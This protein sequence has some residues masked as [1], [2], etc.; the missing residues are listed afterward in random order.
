MAFSIALDREAEIH[1]P[2]GSSLEEFKPLPVS[3]NEHLG[4]CASLPSYK[5]LEAVKE[6]WSKTLSR[7]SDTTRP[8]SFRNIY[9]TEFITVLKASLDPGNSPLTPP[10]TPCTTLS[11]KLVDE[12]IFTHVVAVAEDRAS[13]T[14]QFPEQVVHQINQ[15]KIRLEVAHWSCQWH[16]NLWYKCGSIKLAQAEELAELFQQDLETVLQGLGS[17]LPPSPP[18]ELSTI[19]A[20]KND[21]QNWPRVDQCIH[22]LIEER[23]VTQPQTE[24]VC[25]HDG[26]FT[27]SELSSTS[28][29]LARMLG[30]F[31]ASPEQRVAI[32]MNKS[33]W[34]PM[35]VLAVLKAGAAFVPLD[36]THPENRLKQLANDIEPCVLITTSQ[37]ANKAKVLGC[38]NVLPIDQVDFDEIPPAPTATPVKPDNAAYIIFTSGS[39]GKPKGVVIEHSA[40]ATSAVTRGAVLGLGPES[41]VLQ[42]APHTFDVSVDEI[43]TTLIHGG[44]VCIPSECDRF[45]ITEF[46]E[47]ARVS[48]ALLTPTSARTINPDDVPTLKTLQTGGEVLTEDVNDKWCDRV[49]LFNVYGPTEAS[50]ACVISNRT[51]VRGT[52]HI[53]GRAVGGTCWVVNPEDVS[54]RV[55]PDEIGELVIAGPILARGYFRDVEKTETSFVRL[56]STGERVYRTG[57]LASM[58]EAGVISYHGRKDLEIKIRGQRINIAEVEQAILQCEVVDNVVVEYPVSGPCAKRL[59]AI[60][61]T[62]QGPD[63]E[64]QLTVD[65]FSRAQRLDEDTLISFQTQVSGVLPTAMLPSKWLSISHLPQTAS[66]KVDRKQVRGWLEEMDEETYAHFFH[67]NVSAT[68]DEPADGLIAIWGK[69]LKI[70]PHNL[71]LN[72]SFIRNGGDSIMAMEAR[73]WAQEAGFAIHIPDLLGNASLQDISRIATPITA[74]STPVIGEDTD[75]PFALSPVQQMYFDHMRD[76]HMGLQQRVSVEITRMVQPEAIRAA[77][78]YVVEKHRMLAAKFNCQN[79]RWMQFV[80]IGSNIDADPAYEFYTDCPTSLDDYCTKPMSIGEGQLFHAHR[81]LPDEGKQVLVFCAHHLV[82]DFV[83]WRVILH[84]FHDAIHAAQDGR[85]LQPDAQSSLS[86]QQWCREQIKYA[87]SLDPNTVLPFG[88]GPVD[89]T[90]WQPTNEHPLKNTYADVSQYEFRLSST[91]TAQLLEK[92]TNPFVHPT[93]VIIA[94]F[95]MAFRRIFPERDSPNIFIENHGREPG[96]TL[97]DVSRTVGWFT[98]AYPI[99]LPKVTLEELSDALKASSERRRG[100]PANG[101]SYWVCRYLSEDGRKAFGDE[102]HQQMEVVFNYAGSVVQHTDD[103]SL[104]GKS[105]RTTEVGHPNCPRFSLFDIS[106]SIEQP[107]Q[108]LRITYSFPGNIAHKDRIYE[109]LQTHQEIMMCAVDDHTSL[110]NCHPSSPLNPCSTEVA[111]LLE[112]YGICPE[113][114]VEAVYVASPIQQR[115]LRRQSLEPWY[116]RVRGTWT[117]KRATDLSSPIDL[118]RLSRAWCDVVRR[119]TMLRT[120]YQYSGDSDQYNA[121]VLRD[122]QPPIT[123]VCSSGEN[124]HSLCRDSQLSPPHRMILQEM[125]DEVVECQ[126]EFSHVIIDAASRSIIL[127]ELVDTYEGKSQHPTTEALPFWEYLSLTESSEKEASALRAPKNEMTLSGHVALLQIGLPC[128]GM[129]LREACK[130][131][132]ITISSFFMTAWAIVLSQRL[133]NQS[134]AFDYV[135][136]DRL[137]D[138]TGIEK[139]VGPYIRLPTCQAVVTPAVP[140]TEL[141]QRIHAQNTCFQGS[142]LELPSTFTAMQGYATLVN[143][144]NSGT[145]SLDMTSEETQWILK[146]F[147]DPWDYDLVFAV[148]VRGSDILGCSIEYAE[149]V[150]PARVAVGF[151]DCLLKTVKTMMQEMM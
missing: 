69:V 144:R 8:P 56:R 16:V 115:M 102:R 139:A 32:L 135:L 80:P 25:A 68:S 86:F 48:A 37:L 10:T 145:D 106:A 61:C 84:D 114:D 12:T 105:V 41:R 36:P 101:H 124:N 47:S 141:T 34:Y 38:P 63:A 94:A 131:H 7:I 5:G 28:S 4:S 149:A 24:A 130:A 62:G 100:T 123:Y 89:L 137:A 126:L 64:S 50:V 146:G 133:E 119:H 53:L 74:A 132:G 18:G 15:S 127:Q 112:K 3:L 107:D 120:V 17:Q 60:V 44:C 83:S 11:R 140:V 97:L 96:Q 98:A 79:G 51:G 128:P 55:A 46:M 148:N 33:S 151:A 27:Y 29:G 147:D 113:R 2:L 23:A 91:Q 66:G 93:D 88:L 117:V 72:Q 31:G 109:L 90:F 52:G 108:E 20:E 75:A 35:A 134:I 136:S 95:A 42:Y 122:I 111:S 13:I 118:D 9:A 73:R 26:T 21:L 110:H 70:A 30:Q 67:G 125:N 116:Y 82:V 59:T 142:G 85:S 39:T 138:I 19:S 143:V 49:T 129:S 71:R 76:Q 78:N 150:V 65:W 57:D 54:Q 87:S 92:F 14:P 6:A 58:D 45:K 40:L 77:L 121:V 104:F 22:D 99:H 81:H 103:Q 43:L 1:E